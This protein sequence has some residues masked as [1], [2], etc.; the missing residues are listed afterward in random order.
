MPKTEK[1]EK[2]TSLPSPQRW[3][4]METGVKII[5][6][7]SIVMAVLTGMQTIPAL[8]WVEGSLWALGFGAMIWVI[9]YGLIYVNKLLHR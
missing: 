7:T 4:K 2:K 1:K 6:V 5:I 3:I 8:G 9:F